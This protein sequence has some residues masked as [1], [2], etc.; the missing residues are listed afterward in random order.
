MQDGYQNGKYNK[1]LILIKLLTLDIEDIAQNNDNPLEES[2]NQDYR[3]DTD[4]SII[5]DLMP[6]TNSRNYARNEMF[7]INNT[8]PPPNLNDEQEDTIFSRPRAMF[9]DLES[10]EEKITKI[11]NFQKDFESLEDNSNYANTPIVNNRLS[12]MRLIDTT[13]IRQSP[14]QLKGNVKNES[15]KLIYI[16]DDNINQDLKLNKS[17]IESHELIHGLEKRK[18]EHD[19]TKLRKLKSRKLRRRRKTNKPRYRNAVNLFD[20]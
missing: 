15:D 7:S 13:K 5:E 4:A 11:E 10:R 14:T 8:K 17:I 16:H 18:N 2:K 3:N 12:E 20:S 1:I 6:L 9:P 19:K